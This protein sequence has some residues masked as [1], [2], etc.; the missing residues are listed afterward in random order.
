MERAPQVLRTLADRFDPAAFDAPRG[1]ALLRLRVEGEGE[2]DWDALADGRLELRPAGAEK[3]DARL[4]ADPATWRRMGEDV[5]GGMDAFRRGRL[6]LRDDLH[7]GVGF[8]A[9]TSGLTGPERLEVGRV[10]TRIGDI[11]VLRGGRRERRAAA[12]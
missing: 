6:K 1:R 5:R 2:G 4:S 10:G 11:A 3:P 7:L 8:L 9:A 12:R